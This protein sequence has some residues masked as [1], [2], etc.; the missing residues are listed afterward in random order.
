VRRA[1]RGFAW[2][3]VLSVVAC[4]SAHLP[5]KPARLRVEL[6]RGFDAAPAEGASRV[7]LLVDVTRSMASATRAGPRKDVV[8][9]AA[10]RRLVIG[11]PDATVVS[12]HAL[13]AVGGACADPIHQADVQVGLNRFA[14]FERI[15][16][17]P[18]RGEGSLSSA[19]H[20]LAEN[21]ERP[22]RVVAFTDLGG[23]C[24]SDL[25]AAAAEFAAR[26][27]RL[28]LVVIGDAAVPECLH[29]IATRPDALLAED[30]LAPA[31]RHFHVTSAA[32]GEPAIRS[33]GEANAAPVAI[34]PGRGTLELDLEPPLRIERSF[35]PDS[36]LVLQV[37]EFPALDPPVRKWRWRQASQ[38]M[39]GGEAGEP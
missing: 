34:L 25:C 6:L 23:E 3:L 13:G 18:I 2:L 12:L 33:C 27:V 21:G 35:P 15:G 39:R 38:E 19:L 8:A 16:A 32:R 7:T 28:D 10:A 22:G 37:I 36:D 26:G 4:A 5:P 17:L 14:L 24:E 1:A 30:L 11:L 29:E 9:R 31:P 20:A